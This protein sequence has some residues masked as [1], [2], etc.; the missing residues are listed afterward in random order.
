MS[1]TKERKPTSQ[2]VPM[3]K[4]EILNQLLAVETE[5][6]DLMR[7]LAESE[8][9]LSALISGQVDAVFDPVTATPLLLQQTQKALLASEAELRKAKDELEQ[10]VSE[11][12]SELERSQQRN[13]DILNS[14]KDGFFALK[15]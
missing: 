11:R 13:I 2:T 4:A 6:A 9:A 3:G 14:I 7:R 15:S 1:N 12:T 5:N 10:R 8:A